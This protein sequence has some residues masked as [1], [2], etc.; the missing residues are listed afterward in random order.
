M[1]DKILDQANKIL[2]YCSQIS[3]GTDTKIH[4]T[5]AALD[6]AKNVLYKHW[7]EIYSDRFNEGLKKLLDEP[8]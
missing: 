8:Q 3:M 6:I 4:E 7:H 5:I 1:S 2:D